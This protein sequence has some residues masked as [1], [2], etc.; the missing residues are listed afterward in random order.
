MCRRAFSLIEIL[1]V[2]TVLGI[3]AGLAL[4][5]SRGDRRDI[6]VRAAAEELAGVFR[7]ARGRAMAS[8]MAVAVV[9]NLANAP[10]S[11]GK[12]LNNRDGGHWY[13]LLGPGADHRASDK[14]QGLPPLFQRRNSS[15]NGANVEPTAWRDN[16]I[17][18]HIEEVENS[19]IDERH[20]LP[21][22]KVR[23][24]ALTDVDNGDQVQPGDTF[25][26]TYPR[27]WF[28]WWDAT[29][30]R[31]H[32]WGGYDPDLGMTNQTGFDNPA[33]YKARLLDGRAISPSGFFYEGYDGPI[34]GCVNP[35]DRWVIDDTNGDGQIAIGS[36]SPGRDDDPTQRYELW[37][38]GEARPLI[39]A[40][41]QDCMLLFLPDGRVLHSWM[42]LR[43]QYA[44]FYDRSYRFFDPT[45]NMATV[46]L[47]APAGRFPLTDLGPADRCNRLAAEQAGRVMGIEHYGEA[48][49]YAQRSGFYWVTLGPD[50]RDDNEIYPD[51]DTALRSMTPCYRVGVSRYGEVRIVKVRTQSTEG[52]VYDTTLSGASWNSKAVTDLHYRHNRR[53]DANGNPVGMPIVDTMTARMLAER[54]WWWQ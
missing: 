16:P 52:R 51:A 1:V 26:P 48:T 20:T 33:R 13:R 36:S 27:P 35:T 8:H 14:R 10:G 42:E 2:L 6:E 11:S 5:V 40:R 45:L 41:F 24:I 22:G 3:I 53:S 44:K 28:G 31:L 21:K 17:R 34:T 9:F 39:D 23:F 29:S 25:A 38:Q 12:V 37:R 19:W 50:R 46:T 15:L 54:I 49:W 18:P 7:K 43:H 4:S 30:Q 32:G 47:T